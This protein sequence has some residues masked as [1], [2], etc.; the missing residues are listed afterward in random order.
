MAL[1]DM[2]NGV[3]RVRIVYDG[4]PQSGKTTTLRVLEHRLAIARVVPDLE[5]IGI[6]WLEYQGGMYD[7]LPIACQ[8]LS[9]PAPQWQQR[10]E[11]ML[12]QADAIVI[13]LD[14]RPAALALGLEHIR[15]LQVFLSHLPPPAPLFL[16][17]ANFQDSP[18]ALNTQQLRALFVDSTTKI[19][20]TAIPEGAGVR[21][22]FVMAV[23]L[24]VERLNALKQH[25][26]LLQGKD[27]LDTPENWL[28]Q[29]H[30]QQLEP[31]PNLL[32]S[33]FD[34]TPPLETELEITD[35]NVIHADLSEI[36]LPS[37]ETPLKWLFP[38]VST[39][40]LLQS[41]P[42]LVPT[43]QPDDSWLASN[44]QWLLLSK[45]DW[46]YLSEKK[47]ILALQQ[48]TRWH[49]KALFRLPDNRS[50][51]LSNNEQG[52]H[53]WQLTRRS[54]PICISNE[55]VEE[56]IKQLLITTN[57]IYRTLQKLHTLI[58][59]SQLEITYFDQ[60]GHY[61]GRLNPLEKNL[62]AADVINKTFDI[63]VPLLKSAPFSE[64][65]LLE[66]LEKLELYNP[67]FA[68]LFANIF[69]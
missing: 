12:S 30:Q 67:Q 64:Q 7:Q 32:S 17:Q 69:V 38:A 49:T 6:N 61:C 8:I 48:Q 16:I 37:A 26:K 36:T 19:V 28:Q 1:I 56:F 53:L 46:H 44:E 66:T 55:S 43:L 68:H 51:V 60:Q 9:S 42:T 20:E 59:L 3:V 35:P 21:E 40:I 54:A 62:D 14:T 33:L 29:L 34:N 5:D 13:V 63:C 27:D 11:F 4:L 58:P 47:A 25:F 41:L 2:E 45:P 18:L 31:I 57:N 52:W 15:Q 50:L 23:R 24:A 65:D 10:R 22:T 39:K